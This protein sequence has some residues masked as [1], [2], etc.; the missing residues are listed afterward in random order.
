M[1]SEVAEPISSGILCIE[2]KETSKDLSKWS[3]YNIQKRN[4]TLNIQPTF[5]PAEHFLKVKQL[6]EFQD[7]SLSYCSRKFRK[8][9][10]AN[11]QHSK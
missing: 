1:T 4:Q 7:N 11:I 2:L 5:K 10:V 3:L 9:V 6:N 8:F